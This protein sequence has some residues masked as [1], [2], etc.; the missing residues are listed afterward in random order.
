MDLSQ[1]R[2]A[3]VSKSY[4]K[5]AGICDELMLQAASTQATAFREEW[6]YAVHLL[7]HIYVNDL[8]SARFLWKSMPSGIK[9]RNPEV[10]AVWKIGQCLWTRDHAGVYTAIRGFSWSPEVLDLLLVSAYSTIGVADAAHFMGMNE[11]D[12]ANYVVQ[13]G[14]TLDP[15]TRMLTVKKKPIVREQKVDPSNLQ[16][17]TGYASSDLA[18]SPSH[19]CCPA[20]PS[21]RFRPAP[22][23]HWRPP[24]LP[25]RLRPRHLL[26]LLLL[27][28]LFVKGGRSAAL[29]RPPASPLPFAHVASFSCCFCCSSLSEEV[30]VSD[31]ELEEEGDDG[32]MAFGRSILASYKRTATVAATRQARVLE[33]EGESIV[34]PW[35]IGMDLTSG[36]NQSGSAV[37][38]GGVRADQGIL[39]SSDL[40]SADLAKVTS[41]HLVRDINNT[42]CVSDLSTA[43]TRAVL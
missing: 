35:L 31:S 32:G 14:W 10:V 20:Q 43:R 28:L 27:L 15:I 2:D 26:Q 24:A 41:R 13:Q 1:L 42:L 23:S 36:E 25:P 33:A 38:N 16:R 5:I 34:A 29:P 22:P 8:N 37:E 19:R 6:P 21:H 7:G 18:Q 17:L 12:A 11:E 9:E 4:D 30:E 39:I 3:M 40:G